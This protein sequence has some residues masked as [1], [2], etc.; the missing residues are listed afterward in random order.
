MTVDV[1]HY[2]QTVGSFVVNL[3]SKFSNK[4]GKYVYHSRFMCLYSQQIHLIITFLLMCCGDIHPNP[5]PIQLNELKIIHLNVRSIRDKLD[6]LQAELE[7]YDII[8]LTET[9]LHAKIKT[10]DIIIP[11]FHPPF[12]K[13]RTTRGGGVAV[14]VKNNLCAHHMDNLEIAEL[15]AIWIKVTGK[16]R[17]YLIGTFYRANKSDAY[18]QL[19]DD[20]IGNANSRLLQFSQWKKKLTPFCRS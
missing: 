5:G 16:S 4:F 10:S 8:C 12:R 17:Q 14:Y 13:D 9:W 7:Q 11:G 18:W 15:E 1:M 20:S 6:I 19:I 3:H 2:R